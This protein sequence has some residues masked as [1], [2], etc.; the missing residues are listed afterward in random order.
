MRYSKE[1][2]KAIKELETEMRGL[3]LTEELLGKFLNVAYPNQQWEHDKKFALPE[4][5]ESKKFRFRPDYCC[6]NLKLCVEFDG[7][8]HYTKVDIIK[9]DLKK[10]N[11]L[12]EIGYAIIRVPYFVQLTKESIQFLFKLNINFNNHFQ[13]GF[14]NKKIALPANFCEQG[15]WKFKNFILDLKITHKTEILSQIIKSLKSRNEN[16]ID[17]VPS[18]LFLHLGMLEKN[19]DSVTNV[20]RIKSNLK[21]NWNCVL[22]E[23][24]QTVMEQPGIY[25]MEY[26]YNSQGDIS[27]Y[28]FYMLYGSSITKITLLIESLDDS[29]E[30]V[31]IQIFLN[32]AL[33]R[34]TEEE[35]VN[36]NI[37]NIPEFLF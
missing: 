34:S 10:D 23:S 22:L 11:L 29:H 32:D 8:D 13:H 1:Q 26:T 31:V 27:G 2:K 36:I 9:A 19:Y 30:K 16:P 25:Q 33:Y 14:I 35:A 5:S 17:I 4:S 37:F 6:H 24:S 7:P 28:S 18:T 12:K 15:I 20:H 3:C 21:N